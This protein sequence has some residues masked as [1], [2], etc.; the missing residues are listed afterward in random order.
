M[1]EKL[2]AEIFKNIP[3]VETERLTLR[4]I[5]ISDAEDVF[6]YASRPETSKYLLWYPHEDIHYTKKYLKLIDKRY[7][8][9]AFYDW[10]V[11]DKE[12]GK[13]IGTCGF[14]KIDAAHDRGEI[15]YVLNPDFH[16]KGL[17][18]EAAEAVLRFGFEIL[19]LHRIEVRF[20]IE[21]TASRKVSE[22][23]GMTFEG[24]ERESM[25][26][27]GHYRTIGISSILKN[28]FKK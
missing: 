28:E 11:V 15:G 5:K 16:R 1:N 20:M 18:P 12:S 24:E 17:A 9:G 6:A 25:L 27:K 21:N 22:K 3:T 14:T 10:A 8:Q 19:G 4:R 26:V 23:I 13:M 2:I 7:S